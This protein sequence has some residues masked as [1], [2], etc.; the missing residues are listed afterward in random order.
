MNLCPRAVNR[1]TLPLALALA[2]IFAACGGGEGG[3]GSRA[4]STQEQR[5]A[6]LVLDFVPNAVHTGIYCADAR[7]YYEQGGIDLGIIEPSSTADTLR[8]IGAGKAEFGLADGIDVAGQIGRGRS[9]KGI[10]ALSQRPL[11]GLITLD[12]SGID[13]PGELE[14]S[15]VGVTGLPSDDAVLETMV[16]AAGGDPESVHTV[17]IGFNGVQALR[18]GKVAAFTGYPVADA[19]LVEG[20]DTTA[21]S[22]ALDSFGGPAY[23]GLVAFSTEELIAAE[24]ELV[25][26]FV[27]ATLHGYEDTIADPES[28]RDELLDANPELDPTLAEAQLDGY[29]PL[30]AAEASSFGS[31]RPQGV[32]ELSSFLV[33]NGLIDEAIPIERFATNEFVDAG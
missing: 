12:E 28:C 8:L 29:L 4:G 9:A 23:P 17:A 19:P 14:G 10:L 25:S 7:G 32:E 18:A 13:D 16:R 26:A 30:F 24:P 27:A 1:L 22:F 31:F 3:D 11:G 15:T 2:A 21:R 33:D 20:A 5:E 6:T